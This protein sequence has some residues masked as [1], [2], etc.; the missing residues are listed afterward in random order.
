MPRG[1]TCPFLC[2]AGSMESLARERRRNK[3]TLAEFSVQLGQVGSPAQ[4][5]G[6]FGVFIAHP[7]AFFVERV[8]QP[9]NQLLLGCAPR[10][11]LGQGQT[12]RHACLR[13]RTRQ[14]WRLCRPVVRTRRR[15]VRAPRGQAAG[16]ALR[17]QLAP[18]PPRRRRR[19]WTSLRVTPVQRSRG[20]P[21]GGALAAAAAAAAAAV[22]LRRPLS[23]P[24][25]Q[26]RPQT[27]WCLG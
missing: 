21:G 26:L 7:V 13:C 14:R 17:W 23:L 5:Q 10:V 22:W 19:P 20:P 24:R 3:A 1:V 2:S 6:P 4:A 8:T 25:P 16:P 27:R 15:S 9:L 18:W 11:S 12:T